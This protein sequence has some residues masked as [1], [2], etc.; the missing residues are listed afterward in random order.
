[1][2]ATMMKKV[3]IITSGYYTKKSKQTVCD[4][5]ARSLTAGPTENSPLPPLLSCTTLMITGTPIALKRKTK[6]ARKKDMLMK[7]KLTFFA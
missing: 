1:M 7:T 5:N 4:K 3:P 6:N 2:K